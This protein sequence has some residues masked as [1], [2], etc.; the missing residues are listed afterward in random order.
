MSLG[1]EMR[2]QKPLWEMV[3]LVS[4]SDYL[5]AEMEVSHFAIKTSL[6]LS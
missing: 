3:T 4:Q 6:H 2:R 1:E 5:S